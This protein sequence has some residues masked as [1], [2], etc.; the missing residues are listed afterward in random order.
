MRDSGG[1]G[2]PCFSLTSPISALGPGPRS[3]SAR[4][5]LGPKRLVGA[6]PAAAAASPSG[7]WLVLVAA[8]E[9]AE[10]ASTPA[11]G[12]WQHTMRQQIEARDARRCRAGGHGGSEMPPE[13]R[14]SSARRGGYI[15]CYHQSV[16]VIRGQ[17]QPACAGLTDAM[18]R[19]GQGCLTGGDT[20][21]LSGTL[22]GRRCGAPSVPPWR[23]SRQLGHARCCTISAAHESMIAVV[24]TLCAGRGPA[25]CRHRHRARRPLARGVSRSATL[26]HRPANAAA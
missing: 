26:Q 1:G 8:A 15:S 21:P 25:C 19:V 17:S 3:Q 20:G 14:W 13:E 18:H 23:P 16:V 5:A 12:T 24:L 10:T 11:P 7:G 22:R 9:P 2:G 4:P 6:G